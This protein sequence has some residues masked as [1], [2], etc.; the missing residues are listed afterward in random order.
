MVAA[1]SPMRSV[2][3][4]DHCSSATVVDARYLGRVCKASATEW[5]LGSLA[6]QEPAKRS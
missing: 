1:R 6:L 5:L 2:V 4:V 3:A